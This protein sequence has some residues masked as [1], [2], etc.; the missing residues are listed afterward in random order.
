MRT[1][2][3]GDGYQI[4]VHL[5]DE[6][7][8]VKRHMWRLPKRQWLVLCTVCHDRYAKRTEVQVEGM[9]RLFSSAQALRAQAADAPRVAPRKPPKLILVPPGPPQPRSRGELELFMLRSAA[10]ELLASMC[11]PSEHRAPHELRK[12][13]RSLRLRYHK[14]QQRLETTGSVGPNAASQLAEVDRALQHMDARMQLVAQTRRRVG[15]LIRQAQRLLVRTLAQPFG[16]YFYRRRVYRRLLRERDTIASM[17]WLL[18]VPDSCWPAEWVRDLNETFLALQHRYGMPLSDAEMRRL[19]SQTPLADLA[20]LRSALTH[21]PCRVCLHSRQ[22]TPLDPD[23]ELELIATCP[24]A[25]CKFT[26]TTLPKINVGTTN[27][28]P[29]F[30]DALLKLRRRISGTSSLN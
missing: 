13:L 21:C 19:A 25:L 24:C 2:K 27:K 18:N 10:Q 15:V 17:V 3:R 20:A 26:R 22:N 11:L 8:T 5:A 9:L 7:E 6:S 14:Q 1:P 23:Q 12:R 16:G 28:A 4:C 29:E 30:C